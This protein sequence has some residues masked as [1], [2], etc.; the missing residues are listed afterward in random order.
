MAET[1]DLEL[2]RYTEKQ[3]LDGRM[4]YLKSAWTEFRKEV[5]KVVQ[6]F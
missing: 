5:E 3:E 6:T 4:K 1:F 2:T